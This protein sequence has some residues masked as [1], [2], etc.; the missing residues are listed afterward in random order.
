MPSEGT[1]AVGGDFGVFFPDDPYDVS[2][3]VAGFVEFY[4]TPRVS[5]RS[6]LGW[7]DPDLDG[8]GDPG[9][10]Q[11]RLALNLLYNWEQGV[12]HPFVTAGFGAYFLQRHRDDDSV[13]DAETEAAF[14]LGGGIEYFTGRTVA[15]KGEALY[16]ITGDAPDI[17]DPS[18]LTLTIGLKKYF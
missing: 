18:G 11:I 9:V 12:W 13:G 1:V 3:T 7:A 15:L 10:R 2:P 17:P 6:S 16:H 5:A 4:L 14:N 8:S